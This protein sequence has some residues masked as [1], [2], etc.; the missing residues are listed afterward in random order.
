MDMSRLLQYVC[1]LDSCVAP[2]VF[3]VRQ[4]ARSSRVTQSNPG[5]W[6]SNFML[7]LLVVFYLQ[8]KPSG[9]VLPSL[10]SLKR[11]TAHGAFSSSLTLSSFT[12]MHIFLQ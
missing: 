9:T 12:F 6:I 10:L 2:L 3:V 4:W 8:M 11:L 7:S 5:P 1:Q